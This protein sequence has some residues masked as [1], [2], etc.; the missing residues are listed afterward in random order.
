MYTTS[1]CSPPTNQC[2]EQQKRKQDKL[3]LPSKLLPFD[4]TWYG[5]FTEDGLDSAQ[6]CLAAAMNISMLSAL[7][8]S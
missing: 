4:V 5:P 3:P 1:N 6:H 8:F 7:F 2:A